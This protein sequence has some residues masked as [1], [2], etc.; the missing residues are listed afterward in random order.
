[1]Y[2]LFVCFQQLANYISRNSQVKAG[3]V[4]NIFVFF[5]YVLFL[6]Y[7]I[8]K[9]TMHNTQSSKHGRKKYITL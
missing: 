5:H 3:N 1:M 9:D 8:I 6:L 4:Q 2:R 7:K